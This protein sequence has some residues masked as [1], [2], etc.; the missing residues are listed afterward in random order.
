MRARYVF[1][2]AIALLIPSAFLLLKHKSPKPAPSLSE[3]NPFDRLMSRGAAFLQQGD[4]TNA[5]AV[6]TEATKLAP[7]SVDARLNLANAYLL[8]NEDQKVLIETQEALQL[9]RD[10]AAALYLKGLAH[11]H[12]DQAE[13]AVQALQ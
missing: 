12:L 11:L 6:Y 13:Q 3:A 7:E 4:A 8:A 9:D 5:I 1:W 10:S 2:I